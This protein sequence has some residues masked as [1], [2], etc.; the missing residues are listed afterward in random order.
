MNTSS[1]VFFVVISVLILGTVIMTYYRFFEA[2]DY[3]VQAQ[4]ECDPSEESCFV[5]VCDP[6]VDEECVAGS[7]EDAFYYKLINRLARNAP[8]CEADATT[9]VTLP[10]AADE[11]AC[12]YTLCDMET[13]EDGETCND[14]DEYRRMHPES[15]ESMSIETDMVGDERVLDEGAVEIEGEVGDRLDQ[16]Q[17]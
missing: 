17:L 4:V 5:Y 6:A 13:V 2:R 12:S 14:P 9:C 3:M 7:L 10:C 11:A 8:L 15:E 1:H 16:E